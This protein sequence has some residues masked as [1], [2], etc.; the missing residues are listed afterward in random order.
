MFV[1]ELPL[2]VLVLLK[3][4]NSTKMVSYSQSGVNLVCGRSRQSFVIN[5][6]DD[7]SF[8]QCTSDT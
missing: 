2:S 8:S 5:V 4:L 1:L 7:L 6:V 3:T